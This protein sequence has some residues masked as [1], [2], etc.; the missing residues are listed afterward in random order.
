[1]KVTN[2]FVPFALIDAQEALEA[3][4]R[5]DLISG[6]RNLRNVIAQPSLNLGRQLREDAKKAAR[7][8]EF[9]DRIDKIYD[10]IEF[11]GINEVEYQALVDELTYLD[12]ELLAMGVAYN[13][14]GNEVP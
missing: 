7:I 9:K 5:Q 11:G 14:R 12:G 1:M 2:I 6:Q 8:I 10:R 4:P 13:S 3:Q